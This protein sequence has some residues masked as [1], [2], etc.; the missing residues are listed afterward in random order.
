MARSR[1]RLLRFGV[2]SKGSEAANAAELGESLCCPITQQLL[3]DP[4]VVS[5]GQTYERNAIVRHMK[6]S[7]KCPLTNQPIAPTL[8]PNWLVKK[9]VDEYVATYG[10]REGDEWKGIRKMCNPEPVQVDRR[11][12]DEDPPVVGW[13]AQ[14]DVPRFLLP[15]ARLLDIHSRVITN[16]TRSLA[17]SANGPDRLDG[18]R[19]WDL[20]A[21]ADELKR[22]LMRRGVPEAHA[23]ALAGELASYP[24]TN[25]PTEQGFYEY[26][27]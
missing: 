1:A 7:A 11:S 17:A 5:S 16:L 19:L 9:L 8:V 24:R 4:V 10:A 12:E 14:H 15:L 18:R 2:F 22:D 27:S 6:T 26:F 21:S 20:M 25:A 3:I 13:N 23:G